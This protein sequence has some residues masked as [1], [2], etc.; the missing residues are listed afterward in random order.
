M[1]DAVEFHWDEQRT[2]R[3]T[4]LLCALGAPG[5]LLTLVDGIEPKILGL[6]WSAAFCIFAYV[7]YSRGSRKEPVVTVS[8]EGIHDRRISP[9]PIAWKH[10]A[11]IEEFEAENVP[12]VGI[13]FVDSKAALADGNLMV[14]IIAPVQRLL[15]FPAVSINT[16]LLDGSDAD[17]AD[18]VRR[19]RPALV[20]DD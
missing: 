17:V 6:S 15:G 18:A 11:R 5:L 9:A 7:V 10:I 19:F 20:D 13:D 1:G 8:A 12:F 2:R 3:S 16:S 4:V 14:R